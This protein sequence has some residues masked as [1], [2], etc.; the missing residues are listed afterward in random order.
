MLT[1]RSLV[2]AGF[3]LFFVTLAFSPVRVFSGEIPVYSLDDCIKMALAFSPQ[4]KEQEQD[5]EIA[6]SRLTEAEGYLWPQIEITL[7]SGPA[8]KA[9]GNQVT[10]DFRNDRI[11]GLGFFGSIDLTIIQ[12]L[13]TFG[14]LE[15]S[16]NAAQ[17][18][19]KVDQ[20]RVQEKASDVIFEIKQYYYGHLA[21]LEGSKLVNEITGYLE[22]AIDRTR[23]LIEKESPY[24]TELDLYKLETFHGMMGKFRE[25]IDKNIT[26]TKD[27]LRAFIGLGKNSEFD[28]QDKSL[29]LTE[30]KIEDPGFYSSKSGELR[31]EFIQLNEG[32]EAKK[33]LIEAAEADFYP[34]IFI[35]GFYSYSNASG[36]DKVTNPWIYDYFRHNVGGLAIG[37][38]WN[39]DF[40]ITKAKKNRAIAE[41]LKLERL[42]DYAAVGIP[43]QVRKSY[44]ELLEAKKNIESIQKASQSARKWMVGSILNYDM[45]TGEARDVADAIVAYGK[46]KEE[47]IKSLH[48]YNISYAEVLKN[49]GLSSFGIA[50]KF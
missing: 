47:Y 14:K 30:I 46:I 45:G 5:V 20:S 24:A 35:A 23:K 7:L 4:I 34:D 44:V 19:I 33:A 15:H 36:R 13:Y 9:R 29:E 2:I 27:A 8:P 6:K 31:P 11:E 16:R 21:A 1:K 3:I 40:G 41:H 18:G 43:L 42:K 26:L 38:R 50:E 22:S 17:H 49:S 39:I 25:E 10:S 48:A 12:P 37:L 28:L 32:I